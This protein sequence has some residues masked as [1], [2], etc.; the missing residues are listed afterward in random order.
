MN[1]Y[2][3]LPLRYWWALTAK[4]TMWG[5]GLGAVDEE[6]AKKLR[7]YKENITCVSCEERIHGCEGGSRVGVGVQWMRVSI[8]YRKRRLHSL[9]AH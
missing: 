2:K 7:Q 9:N 8:S 4:R 6:T 1:P 3:P 5:W